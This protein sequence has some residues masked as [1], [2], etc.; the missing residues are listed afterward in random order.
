MKK[1]KTSQGDRQGKV[2]NTM[3]YNKPVSENTYNEAD[4]HFSHQAKSILYGKSEVSRPSAISQ[5]S[6]MDV[7]NIE[8]Q[9]EA[10][11]N[12]GSIMSMERRQQMQYR[13]T[14]NSD[15]IKKHVNTQQRQFGSNMNS[16]V[17]KGIRK[18]QPNQLVY[19][20]QKIGSNEHRSTEERSFSSAFNAK[21]E[22]GN[23]PHQ[24]W[25][26]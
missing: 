26:S 8:S 16:F 24:Q 22:I 6:A 18:I 23:Y 12:D 14:F 19:N 3:F 7:S 4:S 5:G 9:R 17:N 1:R 10:K 13:K 25:E 20:Q 11:S 2:I 21:S 15:F